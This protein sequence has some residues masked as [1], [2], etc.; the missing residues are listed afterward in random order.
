MSKLAPPA[1]EV[2][3]RPGARRG[4]AAGAERQRR[5]NGKPVHRAT[6]C[7][8]GR[9]RGRRPGGRLA[10]RAHRRQPARP[11]RSSSARCPRAPTG[12]TRWARP[13]CSRS[14]PRRSRA[15]SWRCTT[16]RIPLRAYE[17]AAHITNEVFLGELV[18]GMHRWGSTVMII[19]IFLHMGRT[20]VFGAYKYPR[21]LNW[22]I[23]VILLVLTLAMGLT[24]YLLP[25]DQRSFW[26]TVVGVNINAS[27]PIMGPYL[28]DFM[29]GGAEF[30]AASLS[31]FYA[32]H[33]LLDPGP[34][35]RADRRAPLPR[36]Q[37][38]H[39]RPA[40]AEGREEGT[41]EGRDLGMN[42][43]EREEYLREYSILKSQGKPFFPYAV[44]KDGAMACITLL[45]DH[46]DGGP[47][48]RRAGPE[49]RPHHHHLLAAA[50][51]VLL[52]PVRAAARDQA[53]GAR[54]PGHDRHPHD[55]PDAAAPAAVLRPQPGAASA[56]AP[57]RDGRRRGHGRRR[58]PTSRC[59]APSPGRR[60]RSRWRWPRS[61]RRARRW[62]RPRA[63]S[64]ATRSA[65]TAT[66]SGPNLTEIGDRLGRDAIARTLREPHLADALL[67]RAAGGASPSS[68]TRWSSSWP[69][70][71][72][73]CPRRTH[74]SP[75]SRRRLPK[76]SK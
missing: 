38:G 25:F 40:V 72:R 11:R 13:R 70:S 9:G 2:R 60:A 39:H 32:M 7:K 31:R 35:R 71:R 15:C 37:A 41:S 69:P 8:R 53:A 73:T 50:R 48:R 55:L 3:L 76:P 23:G 22:I 12:S 57:D 21:E 59:S 27:G 74:R 58:W 4:P 1:P 49:G 26:A 52:L 14:S 47:V 30:G 63:A 51:V 20:F 43:R 5:R 44:A 42:A 28:A 36:R 65:R 62:R 16:T 46:P 24:G 17:S 66:R 54:V 29:R 64:A 33:M 67:R 68:S 10:R 45:R 56:Q 6:R 75:P 61:T 19:L 18:R 34:D